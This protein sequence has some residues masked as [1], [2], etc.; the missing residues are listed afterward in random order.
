MLGLCVRGYC[1]FKGR[2][3]MQDSCQ[4]FSRQPRRKG[5]CVGGGE[6]VPFECANLVHFVY[7]GPYPLGRSVPER[8]IAGRRPSPGNQ[9]AV[10]YQ[11]CLI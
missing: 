10:K 1:L 9:S 7:K 11:T 5:V 2:F 4:T 3:P 8:L 6:G